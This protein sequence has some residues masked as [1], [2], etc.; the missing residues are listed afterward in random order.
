[1]CLFCCLFRIQPSEDDLLDH[2]S[3]LCEAMKRDEDLT[4]SKICFFLCS[5]LS[6][7]E[8]IVYYIF[9]VRLVLMRAEIYD[10]ESDSLASNTFV[11]FLLFV[12]FRFESLLLLSG[13]LRIQNTY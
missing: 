11:S 6:S 2:V 1:M 4:K 7:L 13:Y 12:C 5:L 8:R 10:Y 3:L 9:L